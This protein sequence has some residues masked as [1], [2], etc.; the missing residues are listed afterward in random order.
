LAD[1][2]TYVVIT[3]VR[4]EAEL[5]S[6]TIESV[7]SQ[8]VRPAEWIIVD[9][10]STDGTGE[11]AAGYAAS[12]NWIKVLHRSDRGF[13]ESG[14]GVM[15]AFYDGLAKVTTPCWD[16]LVKL[17][18]DLVMEPN[19]FQR[20]FAEFAQSAKL[21]IGGGTVFQM[22][23]G[24]RTVDPSPAFHVRGATKIYRYE[25]WKMMGALIKAPGWDTL[26]EVKAN[27]LGWETRTF[28]DIGI[29]QLKPTGSAD[30][31][32]RNAVKNGAANYA[33]GYHPL[34]VILKCAKRLFASP[35]VIYSAGIFVGFFG[36]YF[37]RS[38]R[39]DDKALIHYV[40]QQQMRRLLFLDSVWK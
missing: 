28:P 39:I 2:I 36:G 9:D 18:G 5:F 10:G 21:G 4:N 31:S 29:Q 1:Q 8:S 34:F 40:Q 24:V 20:C 26:D 32:W 33:V 15:H 12:H 7:I 23:N 38:P 19:Y 14:T 27:M 6:K 25:C 17:D 3:P 13:R 11:L 35:Y 37:K 30:G 16:F 22:T